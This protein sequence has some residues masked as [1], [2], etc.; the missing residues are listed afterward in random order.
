VNGLVL[1]TSA[2]LAYASGESVEPGAMIALAGEDPGQQVWIPALC[3]GEATR[4]L[5]GTKQ[6]VVLDVLTGSDSDVS[7][8]VFD[9]ATS[10]RV[11]RIAAEQGIGL[12]AAHAIAT[13]LLYRCYLV[14]SS[15]ELAAAAGGLGVETLDLSQTWD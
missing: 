6:R 11:A 2:L 15:S 5:I 12:D 13:A 14:T 9:G 1:D 8:A 3:L 10:R 7:I 4:Q